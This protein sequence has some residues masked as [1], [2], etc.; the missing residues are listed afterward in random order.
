VACLLVL[1]L[2]A[3]CGG[4]SGS[5]GAPE[6]PAGLGYMPANADVV[7]TMPTDLEGAQLRRLE[8]LIEPLLREAGVGSLREGAAELARSANLDYERDVAPLLGGTLVAAVAG[9]FEE[10]D[11]LVALETPDGERLKR[12]L[13]ALELSPVGEHR[14]ATLYDGAAVDGGTLIVSFDPGDLR[15]VIDRERDGAGMGE[16][17]FAE[18]MDGVP[19]DALLSGF[20]TPP[21]L[22]SI[23]RAL[24]RATSMPW[25]A[26]VRGYSFWT[27]LEEDAVR[28]EL[29]V[30]TDPDGLEAEDLPLEAGED[31][32]EVPRAAGA[33]GGGNRNQSRTTVFLS[34]VA[35]RVFP[36]S[37]FVREVEAIERDLG[38]TFEAE[39]LSQ[40]D[41]PSASLLVREED[42][43]DSEFAAV[44]ELADPGRM[45][46][47]LPRLA[48]RL[49]GVLRGLQGLGNRGLLAL[50][51]VAPDAPLIP[52]ALPLLQGAIQVAPLEG[53]PAEERLFRITGLDET[54]PD[55]R[56]FNGPPAVVFGMIGERFV[57]ASGEDRAREA[58]AMEV[59]PVP[60]AKGAAVAYADLGAFSPDA[61]ASTLGVRTVPLGELVAELEASTEGLEGRMR[62][63]V[64]GGLR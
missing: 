64:P 24:L 42:P 2:V 27:A 25:I 7:A 16:E 30:R 39:V 36:D 5:P 63:Y 4:A 47:L 45:R 12:V 51:L 22:L 53:G 58:A 19:A 29:R 35:R 26:A 57:V 21:G 9:G 61:L 11:I 46:E 1:V 13:K 15:A 23:D 59:E 32:P 8:R 31:S 55:G 20:G 34:E 62:I 60:G 38:V 6:A 10:G 3:G 28:G 40:F 17:R 44:S 50:L 41:G 14:G 18:G 52:G 33:I 48:P 43:R 54:T 49:P 56:A 37:A